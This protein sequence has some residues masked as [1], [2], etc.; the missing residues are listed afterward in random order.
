VTCLVDNALKFLKAG[1]PAFPVMRETKKPYEKWKEFQNRLPTEDE[2]TAWWNQYPDANIGMATGHLSGLVVIDCDSE[3]AANRFI[4]E[5]PEAKDTRQVQTGRGKHF[6]FINE[7]GITNDA[8]KLLGSGIDVRG[9]GGYV[10]APPSVHANGRPYE[11]LNKNTFSRLPDKLKEILVSRF[12]DGRPTNGLAQS[13]G[14][15]IAD[16]Q[17]NV[18]LTSLG[19]TMRRRGM[20]ESAILAALREE[21]ATKCDPPLEDYEVRS[22]AESVAKYPP[23]EARESSRSSRNSNP[24]EPLR[25]VLPPSEPYPVDALR[26]ILA[27]AAQEMHEIIQSPMAICAQSLLAGASL[28]VQAHANINIDG[29]IYPL[30]EYFLSVAESGE[31]KTATDNAA[32]GPHEKR[33]RDLRAEYDGSIQEYEA[34]YAAWKKSHDEILSSK[35][36]DTRQEKTGALLELG[37]EPQ[38]PMNGTLVTKEPT[39]E[40]LV[41]ALAEGFPSMGIFSNEGGRFVGGHGMNQDNRLK[42][43]SGLSE[44]WDGAPISRTRGGDGNILLYGRRLS[45]HLMIQPEISTQLLGDQLLL[46][47]GLLSR[48]LVAYPDST[49]GKR[50]YRSIN[51][52]QEPGMKRY[53]ARLVDILEQPLPLTENTRNELV[54][55]HKPHRLVYV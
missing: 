32:L 7:P 52:N 40:G 13:V 43:A 16:H 11:W 39:Y 10:V 21:N 8:G 20:S 1:K 28:A 2:I 38:A 36:H 51:L 54:P 47:Q 53:F 42:T 45:I 50:P 48:F 4:E 29:R 49:I 30:S 26:D 37:P 12:K 41:K 55:R 3:G 23:S 17:R 5:Y 31:R 25:R 19:G 24:P 35:D 6:Y 14:E 9:E 46:R 34:D 18:T 27:P 44:L 15:K 22:I 33:Q